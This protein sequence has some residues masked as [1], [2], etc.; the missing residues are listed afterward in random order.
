MNPYIITLK[1]E[2]IWLDGF[3]GEF[4]KILKEKIGIIY[5]Q[6]LSEDNEVSI[7]LI[8]KLD[9]DFTGKKIIDQ[10]LSWT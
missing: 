6:S 8:L 5:L 9:K 7:I 1:W 10:Y 2:H 3:T 4:Y